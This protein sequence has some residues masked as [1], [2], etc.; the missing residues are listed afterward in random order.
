MP[1]ISLLSLCSFRSKEKEVESHDKTKLTDDLAEHKCE[2]QQT[3]CAKFSCVVILIVLVLL[4]ATG[5]MIYTCH[6]DSEIKSNYNSVEEN[7]N[8]IY[9]PCINGEITGKSHTVNDFI[10]KHNSSRAIAN[11]ITLVRFTIFVMLFC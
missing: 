9:L 3:N 5:I 7:Q 6:P 11:L 1:T 4:N 2:T 8:V 10:C